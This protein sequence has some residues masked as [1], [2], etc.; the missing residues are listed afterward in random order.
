MLSS[1]YK[2]LRLR[3]V[4]YIRRGAHECVRYIIDD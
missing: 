1:N 2:K 4:T 3:N